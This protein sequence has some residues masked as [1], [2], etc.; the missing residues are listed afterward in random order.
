MMLF[1]FTLFDGTVSYTAPLAMSQIGLSKTMLGM[2]IGT[3]SIFGAIFDFVLSKMLT[4]TKIL[5]V[6]H[7]QILDLL[8][9]VLLGSDLGF[10]RHR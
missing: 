5:E 7:K 8:C 6:A 4:N 9:A 3:S 1:F 2:I 10:L